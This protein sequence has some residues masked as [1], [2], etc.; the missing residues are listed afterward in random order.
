VADRWPND[1]GADFSARRDD[2]GKSRV[3]LERMDMGGFGSGHW[4]P[5]SKLQREDCW[6]LS[7]DKLYRGGVLTLPAQPASARKWIW[8]WGDGCRIGIR[9]T[10]VAG[11]VRL[12]LDYT[13]SRKDR[14]DP[15]WFEQVVPLEALTTS[16]GIVRWYFRC[17]SC[18]RRCRKLYQ[19]CSRR[20]GT[21]FRC[22]ICHDLTYRT[23]VASRQR[24]IPPHIWKQLSELFGEPENPTYSRFYGRWGIRRRRR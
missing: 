15:Q 18:A 14:T 8:T 2:F 16:L 19:P 13:M 5:D 23:R 4:Y 7:I 17:P 20:R 10:W 3:F 6:P 24:P 21:G 9:V 12:T 22:R 11:V 1:V